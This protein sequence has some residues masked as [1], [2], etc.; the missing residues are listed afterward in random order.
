MDLTNLIPENLD[1]T[2]HLGTDIWIALAV[3]YITL[4][5][6]WWQQSIRS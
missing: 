6:H 2:L 3:G 1:I 5:A 4:L